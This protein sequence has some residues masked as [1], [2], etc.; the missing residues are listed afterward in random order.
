MGFYATP[1]PDTHHLVYYWFNTFL[2]YYLLI[3]AS[4]QDGYRMWS[5]REFGAGAGVPSPHTLPRGI[6]LVSGLW[7]G[8]P[9]PSRITG[10]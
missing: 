10:N 1:P 4:D 7:C 8:E 6:V 9:S 2:D 5:I 3:D